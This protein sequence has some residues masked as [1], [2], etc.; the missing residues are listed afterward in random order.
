[1]HET[2]AVAIDRKAD[3]QAEALRASVG[4]EVGVLEGELGSTEEVELEGREAEGDGLSCSAGLI[5]GG[6]G[7][8]GVI[9][10]AQRADFEFDSVFFQGVSFLVNLAERFV[11]E[12]DDQRIGAFVDADA[13]NTHPFGK[14]GDF[15]S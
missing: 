14:E 12:A 6:D 10:D 5:V 7:G 13:I 4:S 1:M 8:G 3:V 9:V 11:I 15:G 2:R